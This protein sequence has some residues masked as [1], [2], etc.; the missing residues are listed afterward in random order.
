MNGEPILSGRMMFYGDNAFRT[1]RFRVTLTETLDPVLLQ[2]AVDEA[3]RRCPWAVYGLR[4]EGGLFY[5]SC[6]LPGTIKVGKWDDT[7][8]PELGGP[9]AQG[10]LVGVYYQGRNIIFSFFHGLTDGTGA[11]SFT[12]KTLQCYLSILKGEQLIPPEQE[13]PDAEAEP[14][15][16]VDRAIQE[17]G[18]ALDVSKGSSGQAKEF[19]DHSQMLAGGAEPCSYLIRA[20]VHG[21]I[22][23]AKRMGI[24]VSAALV[25]LYAAAFLQVHHD[26]QGFLKVALPVD[27]RH[28]L[29]IPHT[30]RNCAMPPAMFD[31]EIRDGESIEKLAGRIEESVLQAVS[32]A[33]ELYSVKRFAAYIDR[34][35]QMSYAKTN[36]AMAKALSVDHPPFTFNCSYARRFTDEE[37]LGLVEKI[38]VLMPA[39][40]S[41][42]I[43]EVVAFPDYFYISMN[44]GGTCETYL[45]AFLDQF[46]KNGI[47]AE[48]EEKVKSPVQYVA[49]RETLGLAQ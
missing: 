48:L 19:A 14:L 10:H 21:M 6:H 7:N 29:G 40:G 45:K 9:D 22:D 41:A 11:F 24:K 36:E 13:Y 1:F 42:P 17:S 34:I 26:A 31:V 37:Y 32:P 16:A 27:F 8:P 18:I 30:F 33:A 35:P 39:Y 12:D 5:T 3:V 4:E 46:D 47:H 38:Y 2:K 44:Q 43:F 25:T 49:L 28:V 20:D 23:F 15:K